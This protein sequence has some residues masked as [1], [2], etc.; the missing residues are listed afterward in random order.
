MYFG[1][2]WSV[3]VP[4]KV[5]VTLFPYK[6]HIK[7]KWNI[8]YKYLKTKLFE[9]SATIIEG[10]WVSQN[11]PIL[12]FK[13]MACPKSILIWHCKKQHK[14]NWKIVMSLTMVQV[15]GG[16][17]NRLMNILEKIYPHIFIKHL[18]EVNHLT[19]TLDNFKVLSCV[20]CNRKFKRKVSILIKQN[21]TA[22]N[23]HCTS[24]PLKLYNCNKT[25]ENMCLLK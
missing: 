17:W 23:K 25:L 13:K 19:V 16:W 21:W 15:E 1:T 3:W 2:V 12:N 7:T 10:F 14:R 20:S 11:Y 18:I 9:F 4:K 8:V 22:L 6:F 24:I 5:L